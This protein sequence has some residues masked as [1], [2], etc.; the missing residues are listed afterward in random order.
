MQENNPDSLTR[1]CTHTFKCVSPGA[2]ACANIVYCSRKYINRFIRFE[3]DTAVLAQV[4]REIF[5]IYFLLKKRNLYYK[6][7][8]SSILEYK[9]NSTYTHTEPLTNTHKHRSKQKKRSLLLEIV[10]GS[11]WDKN[12]T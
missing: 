9:L 7:A 1:A 4:S 3:L 8:E 2:V 12:N 6:K 11:V 5:T 10:C